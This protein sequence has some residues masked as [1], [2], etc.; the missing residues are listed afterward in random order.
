MELSYITEEAILTRTAAYNTPEFEQ[1]QKILD[2][3][4]YHFAALQ[5]NSL[6]EVEGYPHINCV[7]FSQFEMKMTAEGAYFKAVYSTVDD[8]HV[9][10]AMEELSKKDTTHC[11]KLRVVMQ[12]SDPSASPWLALKL[13]GEQRVKFGRELWEQAVPVTETKENWDGDLTCAMQLP[14]HTSVPDELVAAWKRIEDVY[15]DDKN[16]LIEDQ[17][18]EYEG[19]MTGG[20]FIR[21]E[22]KGTELPDLLAQLQALSDACSSL[23][24]SWTTEGYLYS[25]FAVLSFDTDEGGKITAKYIALAN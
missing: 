14:G 4:R 9:G 8:D 3:L 15:T 19:S 17:I 1:E 25:D 18:E 20:A 11:L 7:N 13:P 16:V 10:F 12:H 23:G 5:A 24:G 6:E 2:A 22:L 21:F